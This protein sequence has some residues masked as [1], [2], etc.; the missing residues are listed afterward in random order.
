MEKTWKAVY[1]P[2]GKAC[3]YIVETVKGKQIGEVDYSNLIDAKRKALSYT[4]RTKKDVL[5]Y[6]SVGYTTPR[7]K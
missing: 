1:F 7:R 5:I 3:H 6:K 2:N 4:N